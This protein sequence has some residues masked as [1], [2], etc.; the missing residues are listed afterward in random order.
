MA[1]G[2]TLCI[3]N[4]INEMKRRVGSNRWKM[5]GATPSE[6]SGIH[7]N[8]MKKDHIDGYNGPLE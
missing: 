7:A 4:V 5:F 2:L 3:F 1:E 6:R 8:T